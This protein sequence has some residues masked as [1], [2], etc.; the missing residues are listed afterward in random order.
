M[1]ARILNEMGSVAEAFEWLQKVKPYFSVNS[2]DFSTFY[3]KMLEKTGQKSEII[4]FVEAGVKEN[5]ASPE[6]FEILKREYVS[7]KGSVKDSIF[8]STV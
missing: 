7:K 3:V 5:A 6:M 1:H 4:P 8:M 2:A